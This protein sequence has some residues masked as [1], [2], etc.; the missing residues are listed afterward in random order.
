MRSFLLAL[1]LLTIIPVR[2]RGDVSAND[3][4]R[5]LGGFVFVGLAQG[6]MLVV[7]AALLQVFF[8]IELVAAL[9]LVLYVL[10]SGG[11]HLD[12]I[13]DTFDALACKG[14]RERRLQVMRDGSSGAIGITAMV[15]VLALKYLAIKSVLAPGEF[16]GLYVL[17][18]MPV[19]SKWTNLFLMYKGVPARAE[20]L[21]AMLLNGIKGGG[22]ALASVWVLIIMLVPLFAFGHVE[23]RYLILVAASLVAV[24]ALSVLQKAFFTRVFG[25]HTGDTLGA[26]GEAAEVAFLLTASAC[27]TLYF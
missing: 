8:P 1:Q 9:V 26:A 2:V 12:A 15:F 27:Y 17:F 11:F 18:V 10:T 23:Q 6:V 14:G 20:G 3:M 22:M 4:V 5:S 21:G 16:L 25:G 13:A 19:L 24:V 7:A